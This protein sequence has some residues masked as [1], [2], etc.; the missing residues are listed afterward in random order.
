M[1]RDRETGRR[2][3]LVLLALDR[4]VRKR[5]G[6]ARRVRVGEADR[7]GRQ[8]G[9]DDQDGKDPRRSSPASW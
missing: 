5:G 3:G 9:G 1:G 4:A 6:V 7:D 8:T 2:V